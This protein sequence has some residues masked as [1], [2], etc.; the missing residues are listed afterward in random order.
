MYYIGYSIYLF[1]TYDDYTGYRMYHILY[2][3][4]YDTLQN[5]G[6]YHP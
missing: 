6:F 2:T 3:V 5:T 1:T 4:H